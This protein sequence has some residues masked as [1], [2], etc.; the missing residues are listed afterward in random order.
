MSLPAG[1]TLVVRW[2]RTPDGPVP[3]SGQLG[4]PGGHLDLT[5]GQAIALWNGASPD[6]VLPGLEEEER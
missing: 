1:W 2:E 4:W 3:A 6:D 5:G